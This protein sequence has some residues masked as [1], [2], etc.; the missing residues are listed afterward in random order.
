MKNILVV[1]AFLL[2]VGCAQ[3]KQAVKQTE[4]KHR[5]STVLEGNKIIRYDKKEA[6]PTKTTHENY[7]IAAQTPTAQ[8]EVP[9]VKVEPLPQ[10]AARQNTSA[11]KSKKRFVAIMKDVAINR[12]F[13]PPPPDGDA[14]GREGTVGFSLVLGSFVLLLIGVIVAIGLSET[15]LLTGAVL[16]VLSFAAF[17]TGVIFSIIG[18][19]KNNSKSDYVLAWIGVGIPA[20]FLLLSIIGA[21]IGS[22]QL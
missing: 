19:V 4:V 1:C 6:E 5:Y 17:I 7:R 10:V 18:V 21:I 13:S 14:T 12:T 22:M 2:A 20:F 15:A 3:Q 11:Q 16:F 9:K 8:I